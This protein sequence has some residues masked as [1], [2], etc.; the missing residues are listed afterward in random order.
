MRSQSG[1][2]ERIKWK[3]LGVLEGAMG[4][5]A[6]EITGAGPKALDGLARHAML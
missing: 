5:T 1:L 4:S 2:S 6:I 3:F